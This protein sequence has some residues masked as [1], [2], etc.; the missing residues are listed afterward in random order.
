[1]RVLVGPT[2]PSLFDNPSGAPVFPGFE[3]AQFRSVLDFGCGCG[4][5]ARQFIQQRPPPERYIGIDLHAG[6]IEWCKRNLAPRAQ[7]FE[8]HHHNVFY[9]AFNPGK[10]K[11]LHAPLPGASGEFTLAIAWSVF[12]HLT[13]LQAE[14][15][16]AELAR[17]LAPGGIVLSTW[18]LFDKRDF[19]MMRDEQNTLFINEHDVRNAVIY[20]R[21][22]V[23]RAAADA[24]L[25]ICA[26]TPP[27]V[28]GYQ[29]ELR[30]TQ[31][32]PGV[33]DVELP[34]DL[35]ERGREPPPPMPPQAFLIGAT[36]RSD[37]S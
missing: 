27:S 31:P 22:W 30:M 24:G 10:N 12:T 11:P 18:F 3:P 29:W 5:I 34:E 13:Q 7:G 15:Y 33:Q 21:A 32:G 36:D 6:M 23:R 9:D 16:L 19:P 8:F 26:A 35:S 1:M 17:V 2:D 14:A 25:I 37:T 4:R 28:R 20:D